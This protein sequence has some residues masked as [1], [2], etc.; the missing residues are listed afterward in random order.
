MQRTSRFAS[1]LEGRVG[2]RQSSER[3]GVRVLWHESGNDGAIQTLV[4]TLN[5]QIPFWEKRGNWAQKWRNIIYILYIYICL[6]ERKQTSCR[7]DGAWH[8]SCRNEVQWGKGCL[9]HFARALG[10]FSLPN[11][12]GEIRQELKK[13]LSYFRMPTFCVLQLSSFFQVNRCRKHFF[14]QPASAIRLLSSKDG[15]SLTWCSHHR[16]T[17]SFL[18]YHVFFHFWMPTRFGGIPW[19]AMGYATL[20]YQVGGID[21]AKISILENQQQPTNSTN[22][23]IQATN[24]HTSRLQISKT[25]AA[26][27]VG[28]FL[29]AA[30]PKA[31]A[32]ALSSMGQASGAFGGLLGGIIGDRLSRCC[33]LHGRPLTA[34][35]SVLSEAQPRRV[36]Y[37]DAKIHGFLIFCHETIKKES[38]SWILVELFALGLEFQ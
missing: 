3:D 30:W 13:L 19:N 35:I 8:L 9:W 32:A 18:V 34:Q 5:I 31:K 2:W 4:K 22:Q 15:Q 38:Q 17:T 12:A 1:I 26:L 10:I 27:G 23:P 37:R 24:G 20:F 7:S 6:Q 29:G 16:F 11:F 36:G 21:D 33:P 28:H 14:F 25:Q